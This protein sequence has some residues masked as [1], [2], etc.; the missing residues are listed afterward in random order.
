MATTPTQTPVPMDQ[1]NTPNLW[2]LFRDNALQVHGT[3][4]WLYVSALIALAMTVIVYVAA[5]N[6]PFEVRG[7]RLKWG[8]FWMI[9]FALSLV[10]ALLLTVDPGLFGLLDRFHIKLP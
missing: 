3:V 4:A 9:I 7:K 6:A 5:V 10:L 1:P 8:T 2:E